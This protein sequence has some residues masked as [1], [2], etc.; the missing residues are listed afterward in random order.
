M[1]NIIWKV[2]FLLTCIQLYV[3][4][5]T[6]A[7]IHNTQIIVS[8]NIHALKRKGIVGLRPWEKNTIGLLSKGF[9]LNKDNADSA[10]SNA[11]SIVGG[12]W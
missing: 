2:R 10:K 3:G 1:K 4:S 6:E 12:S 9:K 7:E 8:E 5:A 11:H